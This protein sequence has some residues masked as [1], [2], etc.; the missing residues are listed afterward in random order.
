[1]TKKW[2]LPGLLAALLASCG[3]SETST[4]AEP[5]TDAVSAPRQTG[6][7]PGA[8]S[9]NAPR[10]KNASGVEYL[11]ASDNAVALEKY[12]KQQPFAKV[13]LEKL[14][15]EVG[16]IL[17]MAESRQDSTAIAAQSKRMNELKIDGEVFGALFQPDSPLA[18]C[19]NAG[20]EAG[21]F[22][23]VMAGFM[24]TEKPEDALENYKK[25]SGYCRDAMAEKPVAQ[26]TLLGPTDVTSPPFPGCLSVISVSGKPEHLQ[27][28]CPAG[29]ISR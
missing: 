29:A 15:S 18:Q 20:I 12:K 5:G 9:A 4:P 2:L 27:W 10:I 11:V 17:K 7:A 22:W 6:P 23:D 25:V 28:T 1:M 3:G 14:D 24:T 8:P 16:H 21:K 26:V 13:Y 19:R